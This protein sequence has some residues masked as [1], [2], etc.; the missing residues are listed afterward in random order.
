MK[1]QSMFSLA[2]LTFDDEPTSSFMPKL[3]SRFLC[4]S[5]KCAE[6]KLHLFTFNLKKLKLNLKKLKFNL[7]KVKLNLKK[8]KFNLKYLKF[9]LK[10][11]TQI[12]KHKVGFEI[13]K[14]QFEKIAI[15]QF[16][17]PLGNY[18]MNI[19]ACAYQSCL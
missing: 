2:T 5:C 7:E 3:G 17:T 12:E 4:R 8:M 1:F 6:V 14:I 9:N 13:T 11:E 15:T 10:K 19:P 18:G 16:E